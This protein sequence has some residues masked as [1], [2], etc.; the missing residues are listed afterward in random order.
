MG[1]AKSVVVKDM[2]HCYVCGSPYIHIHH[3]FFGTANRKISDK[4]GYVVPL[5]QEHHTGSAGV[6]FNK[7]LDLHLKKLSQEHFEAHIGQRE[8]FRRV[9]GKSFI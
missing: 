6:H 3:I 9:F 1:K 2:E 7:S 8:D 5:C 4:Y